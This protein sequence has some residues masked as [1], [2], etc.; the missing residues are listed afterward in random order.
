MALP[1]Q[2]NE[3]ETQ[4]KIMAKHI[5]KKKKQQNQQK[6]E[7]HSSS[8]S[9]QAKPFPD[10][11]Q[12]R[13]SPMPVDRQAAQP[14]GSN[15]R[16]STC[17]AGMFLTLVLGL[18]LGS[19]LPGVIEGM[20][21]EREIA[22]RAA[23]T[24]TSEPA[25]P[26]VPNN[27]MPRANLLPEDS[28]PP[29]HPAI[30]AELA[31][32]IADMEREASQNP[33]KAETWIR[34]GN[35]YFDSGVNNQKAIAAY[36]QALNISPQNADVL[37]D[38]GIMYREEKNFEKALECF[39]KASQINPGHINAL[40]NEG[41]VLNTDLHKH[42]EAADVWRRVLEINPEAK[43]PDGIKLEDLIRSLQ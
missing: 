23:Q 30:P 25:P 15:V 34:L 20:R 24:A 3:T 1:N 27:E 5:N 19:L 40:F 21:A 7:S 39:R 13:V 12:T 4:R 2:L 18:Y 6:Q 29:S 33:G 43:T 36:Q 17:M 31:R 10:S 9:Q 38:M 11:K 37:V 22:S 26:V 16:I 28:T 35:L 42:G 41:V 32:H 8:V 14:A